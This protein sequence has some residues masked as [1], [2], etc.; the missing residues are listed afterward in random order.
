MLVYTLSTYIILHISFG[1]WPTLRLAALKQL[2]FLTLHTILYEHIN[3]SNI[4]YCTFIT[5]RNLS[6]SILY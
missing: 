3:R 6:K 1:N 4:I 5:A 2:H